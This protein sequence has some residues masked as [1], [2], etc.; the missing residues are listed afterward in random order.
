MN[1]KLA[2][3]IGEFVADMMM[4]LLVWLIGVLTL[5][6]ATFANLT[7]QGA[8]ISLV[9][10]LSVWALAAVKHYL[11]TG[12]PTPPAPM[13]HTLTAM[14]GYLQPPQAWYA[15]GIVASTEHEGLAADMRH[16][17][18]QME[19]KLERLEHHAPPP[20][21]PVVPVA[22]PAPPVPPAPTPVAPPAPPAAP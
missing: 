8:L 21:A 13:T 17:M 2:S 7:H 19:S 18:N 20:P 10:S 1:P 15:P 16:F 9:L 6:G 4:I 14:A 12:D 22:P 3:L 5:T 11:S